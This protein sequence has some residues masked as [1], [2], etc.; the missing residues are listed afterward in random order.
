MS[1]RNS[2]NSLSIANHKHKI[3]YF[4]ILPVSAGT[5]AYIEHDLMIK[6]KKKKVNRSIFLEVFITLFKMSCK[7]TQKIFGVKC[8][9]LKIKDFYIHSFLN[10]KVVYNIK[11]FHIF[12][13]IIILNFIFLS[14]FLLLTF[15]RNERI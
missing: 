7:H 4:R 9:A 10:A 14:L 5:V 11:Q 6:T 15:E 12:S 1:L 8:C 13:T 3:N 2:V